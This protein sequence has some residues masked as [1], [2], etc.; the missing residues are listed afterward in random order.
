LR[1]GGYGDCLVRQLAETFAALS[2]GR[3]CCWVLGQGF[4]RKV[5]MFQKKAKKAVGCS[6]TVIEMGSA[7]PN[8]YRQRGPRTV[9]ATRHCTHLLPDRTGMD[10]VDRMDGMRSDHGL[11]VRQQWS[12][13]PARAPDFRPVHPCLP[14]CASSPGFLEKDRAPGFH[15]GPDLEVRRLWRLSRRTVGC[16]LFWFAVEIKTWGSAK[17]SQPFRFLWCHQLFVVRPKGLIPV[18]TELNH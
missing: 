9:Y 12:K 1:L 11:F 2:G 16:C 17:G 3:R 4:S 8:P 15:R 7:S 18:R 13:R 14:S 5:P 6:M 10:K